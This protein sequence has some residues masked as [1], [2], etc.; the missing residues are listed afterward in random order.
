MNIFFLDR[1][2][3][4]AA[5]FHCDKHVV[6][7]I[8]ESA[9]LLS[10]A[11]RLLDGVMVEEKTNGRKVKRWRLNENDD[12]YYGATHANHPS[13]VWVRTS[14]HH[15]DWL[16][17]LFTALLKEYTHRY[18][19]THKCQSMEFLLK[20]MPANISTGYWNDPP[21]CMPDDSKCKSAV[22][23]YRNY[24]RNHKAHFAKW[25]KRDVPEWFANS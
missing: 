14:S 25:T 20:E 11:H 12:V 17:R 7:M 6:K 5:E 22:A 13:A 21:Q 16:Y 1:D 10:T 24:Y 4:A 8:L 3:T 19:K 9:Q 15:Y 18:G 2:T 23:A